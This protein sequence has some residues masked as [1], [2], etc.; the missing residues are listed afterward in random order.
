MPPEIINQWSLMMATTQ[1]IATNPMTSVQPKRNLRWNKYDS[2]CDF[3]FA[4]V[5]SSRSDGPLVFDRAD[6]VVITYLR[7]Y[8]I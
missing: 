6:M 5:R 3:R 7:I 8:L 2:N 1:T 4:A